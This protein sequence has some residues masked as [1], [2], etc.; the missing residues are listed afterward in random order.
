[1]ASN[2]RQLFEARYPPGTSNR[3]ERVKIKES[4]KMMLI[5]IVSGK[6]RREGGG[7]SV[8]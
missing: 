5:P 1:M 6:V 3:R 7:E 2:Y 8:H 4:S